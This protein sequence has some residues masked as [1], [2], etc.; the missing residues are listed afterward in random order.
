MNPSLGG[1]LNRVA[2][3]SSS[4]CWAIGSMVGGEG[5]SEPLVEQWNGSAWS[6]VSLP[7]VGGDSLSDVTCAW[8]SEC[9]VVGSYP[10]GFESSARPRFSRK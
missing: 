7:N 5:E 6:I 1:S 4:E 2:C 8:E 10:T 9:W 3:A